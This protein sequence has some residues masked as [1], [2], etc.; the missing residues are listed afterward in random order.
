MISVSLIFALAMLGPNDESVA[1]QLTPKVHT[2][3]S[4]VYEAYARVEKEQATLPPARSVR[5]RLERLLTEDQAG[6]DAYVKVNL[7]TLPQNEQALALKAMW[8][9]ISRHDIANQR[10]LKSMLPPHGWFTKAE[11]GAKAALAAFAVV[12][13]A[14]NDPSLMRD[15][16]KRM[17]A[18]VETHKVDGGEYALLYDRVALDFDHR[19][20]LYGSQVT[21][22]NGSWQLDRLQDPA[23]VDARRKA[24]GMIE[25]EAEYLRHF[26]NEKCQ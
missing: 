26:S 4:P 24:I 12:Q 3:V 19:P 18:L 22:R 21:C 9:E 16:L 25:T 5:E 6:R 23:H 2:L 17:K 20:Q 1:P 15:V 7:S 8:A 11:Y 13:H 10:T 14:A